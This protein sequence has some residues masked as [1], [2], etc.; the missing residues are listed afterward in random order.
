[1]I[2]G[3]KDSEFPNEP[4]QPG[5]RQIRLDASGMDTLYANS[6]AVA[7]SAE[8]I[9]LY[10]GV[11]AP[12]PGMKQPMVKISHRLILI[13][14]HAKRLLVALQHTIKAY[15]ERFGPIELPPPPRPGGPG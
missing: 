5:Q 14:Q 8:E 4:G 2:F 12:M 6:F 1:M 7:S 10:L 9:T 3:E 13:P 15:E 11:N